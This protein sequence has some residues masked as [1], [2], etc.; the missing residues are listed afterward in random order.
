MTQARLSK[1]GW[2]P[3]QHGRLNAKREAGSPLP[4][5]GPSSVKEWITSSEAA[6]RAR[7]PAAAIVGTD[8]GALGASSDV[9]MVDRG[10]D[11]ASLAGNGDAAA[12]RVRERRAGLMTWPGM[13]LNCC[14]L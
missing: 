13:T 12:R 1:Q 2:Q 6:M 5:L 11:M 4:P 14:M 10:P 9:A 8:D 7:A 3:I